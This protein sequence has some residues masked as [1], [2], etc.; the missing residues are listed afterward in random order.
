M[1]PQ[2]GSQEAAAEAFLKAH[3]A[4]GEVA[5]VTVDIG[6]N[7][8]DGCT[9]PGE[10]LL[11][12]VEAG[13][14]SIKR[15]TPLIL[16][17]L[18]KA[19]PKGTVFAAMNVYDPILADYLLSP[20]SADQGLGELSVALAKSVNALIEAADVAQ[21]FKTADVAAAF[22]TYDETDM[23]SFD[24]KLVPKN[25]AEVCTLTWAC[26]APPQGP[27]IH[28]KAQGYKLIAAAFESALGK[29]H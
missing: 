10:Q 7:D 4:Q 17:G 15:N 6:A 22:D 3:H 23:V 13:E 25:V 24:G 5:L 11:P 8:V 18:R 29:L 9:A 20:Y 19:A 2:G 26:T 21:G 1:R 12:C 27:N 14:A 16:K 28:A